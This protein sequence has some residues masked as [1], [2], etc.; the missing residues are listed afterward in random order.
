MLRCDKDGELFLSFAEKIQSVGVRQAY[1][2][3]VG[4]GAESTRYT[5]YPKPHGYI[6]SVRYYRGSAWDH[7][8]I[9][10]QEWLTFYFRK[11]CLEFPRF[12]RREILARYPQA[13]ES[14]AGEFIVR[15]TG[16]ED[17]VR[18]MSHVES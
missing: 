2:Y 14:N 13:E 12:A 4:W 1:R 9:P 10:N 16:L 17:A 8:F 3:L 7:A 5:C 15:V 6:N 18:I 11:P